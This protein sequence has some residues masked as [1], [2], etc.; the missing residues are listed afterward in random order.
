MI[1]SKEEKLNPQELQ[2]AIPEAL[3][4]RPP[5]TTTF[6]SPMRVRTYYQELAPST[7]ANTTK[8]ASDSGQIVEP[9]ISFV[10][11]EAIN[12]TLDY[13]RKVYTAAGYPAEMIEQL[14]SGLSKSSVTTLQ[15]KLKS[16]W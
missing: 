6:L 4:G 11:L 5:M 9:L 13:Y 12:P 8:N 1:M 2:V 15:T 10:P 3:R 7:P 14:L 16:V